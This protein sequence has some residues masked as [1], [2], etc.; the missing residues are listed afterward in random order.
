MVAQLRLPVGM[1]VRRRQLGDRGLE[2]EHE[3][4][5]LARP[6]HTLALAQRIDGD[7]DPTGHGGASYGHR[8]GFVPLPPGGLRAM[9]GARAAIARLSSR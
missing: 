4:T 6:V 7:E 9:L 1:R 5:R 3:H 8:A 2:L